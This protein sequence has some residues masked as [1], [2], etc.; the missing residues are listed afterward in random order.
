ML[1]SANGWNLFSSASGLA[2]GCL[3]LGVMVGQISEETI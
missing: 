2:E 3:G 1:R